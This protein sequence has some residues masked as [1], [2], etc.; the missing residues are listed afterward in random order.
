MNIKGSNHSMTRT[1]PTTDPSADQV[2]EALKSGKPDVAETLCRDYLTSQPE[3]VEHLR[4]L[5]HALMQQQRFGEAETTLKIA[6]ELAPGFPPLS[7]DL[8]SALA[9]QRKFEE[10]IPFLKQ[11]VRQDPGLV[12]AQKKLGQALADVGRGNAMQPRIRINAGASIRRQAISGDHYCVIVDDFLQ[13]PHEL[14]DFAANRSVEFSKA[15]SYYPGLFID[16]NDDAMTDIH[17]FIRFQMTKHF[18]FLRDDLKLS[19]FLAMATFKPDEL[20][21]VQ[22]MCHTD[23]APDPSRKPYAALIYLFENEELGGTSFFNYRKKY[24]LLKEVEAMGREDPDKALEFLL[25]NFPT[26]RKDADYMTESNEIAELL[27][28]IPARFNRM[29]F[30]SGQIPHSAAITAPELLSKD[31]RKGRLTLNVFADVLPK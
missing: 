5:G 18:P 19:T 31:I 23:P 12:N 8:G 7:E 30:Y 6:I 29:I 22:R 20:S 9:L 10:A 1:R 13:D 3:S 11:A 16:V 25:E 14:I 28:T 2:I 21:E 24:D 17:H 4:L 26:F 15:K 27:R